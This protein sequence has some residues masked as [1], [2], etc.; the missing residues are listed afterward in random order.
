MVLNYSSDLCTASSIHCPGLCH[1]ILSSSGDQQKLAVASNI[2]FW[3]DSFLAF[4]HCS[5]PPKIR[6]SISGFLLKLQF[7]FV[8]ICGSPRINLCLWCE[9]WKEAHSLPL[10]SFPQ[11]GPL[12]PASCA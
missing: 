12:V 4:I 10:D 5:P 2:V 11:A 7:S 3:G 9:G 6:D 1:S 8:L